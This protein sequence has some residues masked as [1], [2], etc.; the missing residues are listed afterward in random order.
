LA[1][2]YTTP[3]LAGGLAFNVAL[4]PSTAGRP[5]RP[6]WPHGRCTALVVYAQDSIAKSDRFYDPN[7]DGVLS[8]EEIKARDPNLSPPVANDL[9]RFDNT[10]TPQRPITIGHGTHDPIV[11]PGETTAHKQLVNSA[12]ESPAPATARPPT[13]SPASATA[14]LSL[15]P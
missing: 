4:A 13:T 8:L 12:S 14:P 3:T 15:T 10:A 9:R 7:H 6:P 11:S 1:H 5:A 2:A